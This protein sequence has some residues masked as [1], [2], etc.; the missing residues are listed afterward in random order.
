MR[1]T[2]PLTWI[3]NTARLGKPQKEGFLMAVPLRWRGGGKGPA[4]K[5]KKI[6]NK[7]LTAIKL[8]VGVEHGN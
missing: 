4:I 2:A 1:L 3:K 6:K 7:V 5:G 8:E